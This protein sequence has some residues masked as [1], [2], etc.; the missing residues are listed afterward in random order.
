MR[1]EVMEAQQSLNDKGF[2]AGP[3]DGALGPRTRA[4]IRQFQESVDLPV[5]GRL[6]AATAS[7]LGGGRESIAANFKGVGRDV[8]QG[9][10]ELGHEVKQGELVAAAE[11][12]AKEIGR[13]AP[14]AGEGVAEAVS[15][16]SDRGDREE[17]REEGSF[18]N[19]GR[20][21]F[22]APPEPTP[23]AKA[24]IQENLSEKD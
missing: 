11:E 21:E 12:F 4:G 10:N 20:A 2:D 7:R 16:D 1:R 23:G 19:A 9:G 13:A 8:A 15:P 6:D 17:K 3:A 18:P 22:R 24:R 14:K 5:T